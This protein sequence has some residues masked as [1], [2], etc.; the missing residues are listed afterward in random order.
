MIEII[1][2]G[3]CAVALVAAPRW[4]GSGLGVRRHIAAFPAQTCLRTALLK[5][6]AQP[7]S[8]A[9]VSRVARSEAP[10]K[11]AEPPK[12]EAHTT[13]VIEGWTVHIDRRLLDGPD[14]ALGDTCL[15]TLAARLY[16][17]TLV[18]P[19]G[20]V[21]RLQAV[22]IW[23]DR[24]NGKLQSMQ[25]HPSV[26]WLKENGYD[27]ALA[28]CVHIP[29][30]AYFTSYAIQ[31]QQPWAVLHELAHAYHDQVL[32]FDNA[33]IL[34]AWH[35]FAESGKYKSVLHMNGR[36]RPHY[37][38]TDQ[39]EFF[40]EMTEAY[41]GMNDFYPFNRPELQHEEPE[42]AA[43]LAKIWKGEE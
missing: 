8:I 30:A 14:K 36:L 20:K 7:S 6:S 11:R 16:A 3:L 22:P 4:S 10:A 43:L 21:K 24:T 2:L 13:R 12:P 1:R 28:R 33:E 31:F 17:I 15:H 39:K 38:L 34:A 25:Y 42:L 18:L 26:E 29:D 5:T 9:L 23:V 37:G 27:P 40:A 41:F 19:A 32:G 35:K